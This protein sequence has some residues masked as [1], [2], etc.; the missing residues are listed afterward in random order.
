M[1]LIVITFQ[2][3]FYVGTIVRSTVAPHPLINVLPTW[4][5]DKFLILNALLLG[6]SVVAFFVAE[7][8]FGRLEGD[9]ESVL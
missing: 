2:R 9:F 6:I 1:T 4:S 3:V 8:I 5:F 7:A